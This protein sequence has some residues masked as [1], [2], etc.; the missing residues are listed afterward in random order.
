MT[1]ERDWT[2]VQHRRCDECGFDA[3]AIA[4]AALGASVRGEGRAWQSLVRSLGE[5]DRE[6][7]TRRVEPGRWSAWQCAGH[8]RDVLAIFSDRIELTLQRDHPTLTWWDHE[9]AALD[10][11]SE[12]LAEIGR[13]LRGAAD[14]LADVVEAVPDDGWERSAERRPGEH[15]T[16]A[17]QARFALHEARHHR[18]DAEIAAG[19]PR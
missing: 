11:P 2:E 16:V 7:A 13:E 1:D 5:E 3:S 14:R 18:R 17:G 19:L 9:A 15:F 6:R 8:V 12:D 10:Y 4:T